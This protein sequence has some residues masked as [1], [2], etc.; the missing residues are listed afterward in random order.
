LSDNS[1]WYIDFNHDGVKDH[2]LIN[3]QGTASVGTAFLRSGKADS[4]V[5]ELPDSENRS[6]DLAFL[7]IDDHYYIVAGDRSL[8]MLW[9]IDEACDFQYVCSFSQKANLKIELNK[10]KETAV[11]LKAEKGE[12]THVEYTHMHAIVDL[13]NEDRFWS[14]YISGHSLARVDLDNDGILDNVIPLD[15]NCSAG[16]GWDASIIATTDE[17][18]TKIPDTPLN[19]IL[20]GEIGGYTSAPDMSV[21]I[22]EGVTY[23]DTSV[24]DRDRKIYRINGSKVE[25]VCEF[26]KRKINFVKGEEESAK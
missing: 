7:K 17:T 8:D 4:T 2:F 12:V 11:C 6:D 1:Y 22:H 19:H 16:R 24:K 10:G 14:K 25:T 3:I 18:R 13:P 20:F 9:M 26:S 23:L 15:F 5:T 21:F